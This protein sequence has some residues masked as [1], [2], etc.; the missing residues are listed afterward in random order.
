MRWTM[1][2]PFPGMD[3]F[4]EGCGLWGDFHHSLIQ[5]IKRDLNNHLPEK[6]L[7]RT[8]AREY[9]V[10]ATAAGEKEHS[11]SADVIVSAKPGVTERNAAV[12]IAE[13]ATEP[14]AISA[15]AFVEEQ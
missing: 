3:P 7:A 14:E 11:F 10:L 15:R 1:K 12:A 6:Y 9:V 13:P 4:I 5:E 8:G 2:S